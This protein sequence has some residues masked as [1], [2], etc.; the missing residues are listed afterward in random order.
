M[1]L[2]DPTANFPQISRKMGQS[3]VL[4]CIIGE[5]QMQVPLQRQIPAHENCRNVPDGNDGAADFGAL[6]QKNK[7]YQGEKIQWEPIRPYLGWREN[8]EPREC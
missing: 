1:S 7:A 5:K 3:Q 4:R 6:I 2:R 8:G